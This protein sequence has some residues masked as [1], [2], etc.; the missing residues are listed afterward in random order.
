M[1]IYHNGK[2]IISIY[3]RKNKI[4]SVY[5]N[6]EKIYSSLLP[7]GTSLY[8]FNGRGIALTP[9]YNTGDGNTSNFKVKGIQGAS[10]TLNN[11]ISECPNGIIV[12][13]KNQAV[14]YSDYNWEDNTYSSLTFNQNPI[15]I[16][17]NTGKNTANFIDGNHNEYTTDISVY[18]NVIKFQTNGDDG[19]IL[20]PYY[21]DGH[22][23]GKYLVIESIVSY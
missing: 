13:F 7:V 3:H 1:A 15:N 4:K 9:N 11:S 14:Y 21:M 22:A 23:D 16:D 5:H 6:G 17:K 8:N 12:K 19:T 18:N 20:P 10:L 2:K